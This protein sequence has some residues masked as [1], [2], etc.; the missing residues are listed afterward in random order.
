MADIA[1][2][3]TKKQRRSETM[4]PH[5]AM[6]RGQVAVVDLGALLFLRAILLLFLL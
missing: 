4:S 3:N 5:V 6:K 1:K 2:S